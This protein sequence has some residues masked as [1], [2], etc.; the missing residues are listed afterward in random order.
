MA[1]LALEQARNRA[2]ALNEAERA[3]LAHDL[4]A[5]LDGTADEGVVDAWDLEILQRLRQI[6][7]GTAEFVDRA[8]LEQ[9]MKQ[10]SAT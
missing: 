2:L 6:D 10:G 7:D 9:R 4:V 5:S 3:E 8:Q 1:S